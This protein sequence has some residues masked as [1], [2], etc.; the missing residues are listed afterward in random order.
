MSDQ[1]GNEKDREY[2][3]YKKEIMDCL[4]RKYNRRCAQKTR[5]NRRIILKPTEI[6]KDYKKNNADILRKQQFGDAVSDL[7]SM[8]I[9]AAEYLK[10]SEDI[11]KIYLCEEKMD[12]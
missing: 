10:Y 11:E 4:L 8:G 2:K 3:D 1:R 6:Y 5:T 7:R 9:I 12:T